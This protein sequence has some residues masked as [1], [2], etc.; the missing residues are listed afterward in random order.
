MTKCDKCGKEA[1]P[2]FC[3]HCREVIKK[4][5][6][7]L[8]NPIPVLFYN[9]F[10]H[11]Y[12]AGCICYECPWNNGKGICTTGMVSIEMFKNLCHEFDGDNCVR[13]VCG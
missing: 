11:N 3:G 8:V 4:E 7:E 9:P 5:Q 10:N 13:M 1:G 2:L 6:V 12:Y